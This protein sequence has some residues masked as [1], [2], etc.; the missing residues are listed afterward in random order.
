MQPLDGGASLEALHG[1]A[2]SANDRVAAGGRDLPHMRWGMRCSVF[3]GWLRRLQRI[4]RPHVS[5]LT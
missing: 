1:D 5:G 2:I 4:I 3:C